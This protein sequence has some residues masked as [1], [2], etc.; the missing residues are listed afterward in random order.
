M[1]RCIRGMFS[2]HQFSL[3]VAIVLFAVSTEARAGLLYRVSGSFGS[4]LSVHDAETF[5]Q[6]ESFPIQDVAITG[7]TYDP[8]TDTLFASSYLQLYEVNRSTGAF[9]QIGDRPRGLT[10]GEIAIQPGTFDLFGLS[11]AGDLYKFDKQSGALTQ[12]G[13]DPDLI[14]FAHALAFAPDGTLY[15]SDNFLFSLLTIDPVT[16][17]ASRFS[18]AEYA[19]INSLAVNASGILFGVDDN[20]ARLVRIN[21]HDGTLTEVRRGIQFSE[22]AFA[23][24][25]PAAWVLLCCAIPIKARYR[26]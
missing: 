24:P 11:L 6:I 1:S 12:I 25:E 26:R 3:A 22:I 20:L 14:G 23:V 17:K 13:G 21:V 2:R 8:S 18:L 4:R 15:A 19:V 10:V 5:E 7:I 16:G 9:V